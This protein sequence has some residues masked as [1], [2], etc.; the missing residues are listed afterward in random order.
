M[1]RSVAGHPRQ[2]H[3]H[4]HVAPALGHV[5]AGI[6]DHF[7]EFR[8]AG[9]GV[10]IG[11]F[12]AF[13]A[14]ELI[15]GHAG[16]ASLDV[17]ERLV[18]TAD[19]VIEHGA[20]LPVRRVVTRLP[21]VLDAVGGLAEQEGLE[22]SI[23]GGLDEIGALGEGGA[24]VSVEAVLIGGDF[25]DREAHALRLALDHAD[26]LDARYGQRPR[27]ACGLFFSGGEAGSDGERAGRGGD[28][29]QKTT[30]REGHG[31]GPHC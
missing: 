6:V 14:G 4:A 12:A 20:V 3:L 26:V 18:D 25:H 7:L 10:C 22:I 1:L 2:A 23:H 13:S 27:G 21:D 8:A 30:A 24:A 5:L 29:L 11:G 17:P 16:L 31:N 28:G 15:H 9:M 19:G